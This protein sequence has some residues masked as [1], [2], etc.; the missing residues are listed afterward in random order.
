MTATTLGAMQAL[1]AEP[2]RVRAYLAPCISADAFEVGEEVAAQFRPAVVVRRADWP[3]PHIDLRA[4]LVAQLAEAGV[5]PDHVEVS[6]AC[7]L[8]EPERFY[9]YRGEDGTAG[10]MLGFIGLETVG[11]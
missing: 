3:R 4:E 2:G 1:G 6:T 10:R 7:T 5:A 11:R 8:R 9:S